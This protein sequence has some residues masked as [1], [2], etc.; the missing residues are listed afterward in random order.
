MLLLLLACGRGDGTL[1]SACAA[2]WAVD[3]LDPEVRTIG[4]LLDGPEGDV[5]VVLRWP[6]R[7]PLNDGRWPVAVV[8]HG[9]WNQAGTPVTSALGRV[10]P[11]K[12]IAEVHL[13]LPGNGESEGVNDRRGAGS[14]AALATVLAWASGATVDR[15]GCTL[16]D[17]AGAAN[18]DDL[19]LVGTSNGGNLA[20]ATLADPSLDL[21]PV[22]GLVLWETPAAPAF[23]N[24]DY[25]TDPSVYDPGTCT[26]EAQAGIRC[27]FPDEPLV[28]Q[29]LA[30][31]VRVCFDVDADGVCTGGDV[32]LQGT[33]D[34]TLGRVVLSPAI[35]TALEAD[36]VDLPGQGFATAAEA[37]AW[38][39]ERDGGRLV[40][41]AVARHPDLPVLL[42]ASETDHVQTLPDHPH[43][44]GLGEALQRSGAAWTRLNPGRAWLDGVGGENAPDAPLR[45]DDPSLRLLTEAEEDPIPEAVGAAVLELSERRATG[46]WTDG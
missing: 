40:G 27:A 2:E 41:D 14:R 37:E 10:D 31:D 6:R 42:V 36:G 33:E 21:P 26:W 4:T 8:L 45:L 39:A 44:Y 9:G 25:G 46:D 15:G 38:W 30:N 13:D 43:V 24:V 3:A 12:G 5:H 1:A 32:T 34:P 16:A 35:A 20:I 7:A 19:H 23:A 18:P 22:A 11:A 28:F 29:V 17:R